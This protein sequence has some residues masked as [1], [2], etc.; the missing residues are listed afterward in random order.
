M[1]ISKNL[2]LLYRLAFSEKTS[3]GTVPLYIRL[4]GGMRAEISPGIKLDP[5]HWDKKAFRVRSSCKDAFRYN[6][7]LAEV[8][9]KI[10]EIDYRL[11]NEHN[12]VTARMVKEVFDREM[13]GQE[14]GAVELTSSSPE[15]VL[16]GEQIATTVSTMVVQPTGKIAALARACAPSA[17]SVASFSSDEST[18]SAL[19]VIVINNPTVVAIGAGTPSDAGRQ[20]E[21]PPTPIR[22]TLIQALNWKYSKFAALVKVEQ[23]S[24]NTLKRW[25]VTKGK[26]RAF[27]RETIGKPDIYL[28]EVKLSLA[29]DFKHFLLTK[30]K[31][32][33]NT[34]GKYLKNTKELLTIAEDR[35]WIIKNKWNNYTIV[36]NQPDRKYLQMSE[37]IAL[38]Q[39]P[40]IN[41]LNHPRN[42]FLFACFTGYAFQEVRNLK[43]TDVFIGNDGRRWIRI[44]RQKTTT[45]ECIPLLPMAAAIVDYYWN[46]P[47]C[48]A[49]NK[50]LPVKSNQKYNGYLK[51]VGT[52]CGVQFDLTTH[53]AR[54]TFAT[55]ICL[56]NGVPLEVVSRMLGHKSI[57]TTQIYAKITN[58]NVSRNMTQLERTLFTPEGML[59]MDLVPVAKVATMVPTYTPAIAV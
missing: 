40:L 5:D 23:R 28:D 38:F 10:T 15:I 4:S 16:P 19:Q 1:R 11:S 24:S 45:E 49:K 51:E 34:A 31:I 26:L 41:R 46:D 8:V 52:I 30:Q 21:L 6:R 9:A 12:T 53:V 43:R 47:D 48:L 22:R 59:R 57:R 14:S 35:E 36:Y 7:T 27:L 2:C 56:D 54:H 50:L 42:V 17:F 58:L 55:T 29:D 39:K 13:A 18:K 3:D 20:L 44:C 33:A 32:G 37:V 25:R